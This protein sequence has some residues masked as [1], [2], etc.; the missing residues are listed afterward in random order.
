M[1]RGIKGSPREILISWGKIKG[2]RLIN[3]LKLAV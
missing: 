2:V 1:E 3:N